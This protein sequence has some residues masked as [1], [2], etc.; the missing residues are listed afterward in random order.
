MS[1][2]RVVFEVRV[3]GLIS[4]WTRRNGIELDAIHAVLRADGPE[5]IGW[6]AMSRLN[7]SSWDD[8]TEPYKAVYWTAFDERFYRVTLEV[9]PG[10]TII[11]RDAACG[12]Y[13]RGPKGR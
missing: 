7:R 6:D 3:V 13:K 4:K 2:W 12:V 5:G 8:L 10:R 11:I 1:T 9:R